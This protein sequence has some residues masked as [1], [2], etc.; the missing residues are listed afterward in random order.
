MKNNIKY[1]RIIFFFIPFLLLLLFNLYFDFLLFQRKYESKY[2]EKNEDLSTIQDKINKNY[3]PDLGS[4]VNYY[5][6]SNYLLKNKILFFGNQSK[7]NIV[8]CNE[9]GNY[10]YYKSDKYGFRNNYDNYGKGL[11]IILGDSFGLGICHQDHFKKIGPNIINLSVAGSGPKLQFLVLKAYLEKY[12]TNKIIIFFYSGNDLH[13]LHYENKNKLIEYFNSRNLDNY[14]DKKDELDKVINDFTQIKLKENNYNYSNFKKIKYGE[15]ISIERIIKFTAL[16]L[17]LRNI[18][19]NFKK[20]DTFKNYL[21]IL[22]DINDIAINKRIEIHLI[23]LPSYN[24]IA[25]K[26][27]KINNMKTIIETNYKNIKVHN[28]HNIIFRKFSL[29]D[30]YL[31]KKTHYTDRVNTEL[32]EFIFENILN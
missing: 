18:Y 19:F 6:F 15:N 2:F 14:F 11:P 23:I 5:N 21:S 27:I 3:F 24:E 17:I 25:K 12:Y 32:E 31:T 9:N 28:F 4:F 16:R 7:Q 30:T 13:D 1:F 22:R 29:E 26:E 20:V 10:V 8:L